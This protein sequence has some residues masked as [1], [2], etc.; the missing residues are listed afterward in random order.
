[1][2]TIDHDER[3]WVALGGNQGDVMAAFATAQQEILSVSRGSIIASSVYRSEPWGVS[4]QP[5][6]LNQVLGFIPTLEPN[7]MMTFLL[8][9]EARCGRD[10]ARETRWGPRTLDLDLLCW[11]GQRGTLESVILPHPRLEER[12]FVLQPWAEIAPGLTPYGLEESIRTLLERCAD[13][14][15]IERC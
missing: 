11:P 13:T 15:H 14:G 8:S 2:M 6:F 1:M 7:P 12:R 9:I 3:A 10:R 5:P 4:E